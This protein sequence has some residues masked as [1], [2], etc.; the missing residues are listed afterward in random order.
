MGLSRIGKIVWF[1][2]CMS[3]G[4]SILWNVFGNLLKRM[5]LQL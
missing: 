5:K 3:F 4:H 2:G 1:S